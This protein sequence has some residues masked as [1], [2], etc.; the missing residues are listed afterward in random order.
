MVSRLGSPSR[1]AELQQTI[2][3]PMRMNGR[4]IIQVNAR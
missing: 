3:M 2:Y 4:M 1:R